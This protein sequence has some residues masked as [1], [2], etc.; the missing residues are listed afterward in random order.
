MKKRIIIILLCIASLAGFAGCTKAEAGIET[1]GPIF[2]EFEFGMSKST[3]KSMYSEWTDPVFDDSDCLAYQEIEYKGFYCDIIFFFDP[4]GDHP[5]KQLNLYMR[6][7]EEN[8]PEKLNASVEIFNEVYGEPD[9]MVEGYYAYWTFQY[10]E[11]DAVLLIVYDEAL[12]DIQTYLLY[13]DNF[14]TLYELL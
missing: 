11:D 12:E 8:S 9:E 14:E 10:G 4:E 1:S 2:S 13:E 7:K 3:I 6:P 5:L